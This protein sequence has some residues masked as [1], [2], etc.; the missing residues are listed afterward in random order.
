MTDRNDRP[1][2]SNV[3]PDAIAS[4]L[5]ARA[6]ELDAL[7]NDDVAVADLRAAAAEAGISAPAFDAA[8]AELRHTGR[9]PANDGLPRRRRGVRSGAALLA[10]A[11]VI[12]AGIL[13]TRLPSPSIDASKT[14]PGEPPRATAAIAGPA[15]VVIRS[16]DG[17]P[18]VTMAVGRD[19]LLFTALGVAPG[20]DG[21]RVGRVELSGAVGSATTPASLEVSDASGEVMF[22]V[23]E[24]GPALELVV[25]GTTQRARG[26]AVRLV[27]DHTGEPL[28]AEVVTH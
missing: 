17:A 4:R 23:P 19:G 5:L 28:R 22:T 27:R 2:I 1:P 14:R 9:V 16:A 11:V 13:V 8:L 24:G 21:R 26:H 20:P 6:S 3:L 18:S 12:A 7:R 25:P 15:Q 10:G